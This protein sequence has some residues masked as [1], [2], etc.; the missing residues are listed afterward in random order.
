MAIREDGGRDV[1]ERYWWRYDAYNRLMVVCRVNTLLS[2]N[3]RTRTYDGRAS[4]RT[5][6]GKKKRTNQRTNEQPRRH[7]T[8][9]KMVVVPVIHANEDR[10]LRV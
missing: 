7:G 4:Q 5:A 1:R 3:G 2:C 8:R 6:E 9:T 10:V